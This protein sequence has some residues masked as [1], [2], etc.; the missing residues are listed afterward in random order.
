MRVL[1]IDPGLASV[2]WGVVESK[3]NRLSHVARGTITT[4]SRDSSGFRLKKIY[5][6]L[7]D[8]IEE[9]KPD[10]AAL[11]TLYFA[12]NITSA[13]PVAQARGVLLLACTEAGLPIGE[14]TPLEIKQAVVGSGR[15]EKQQVEHMVRLL[16][17]LREKEKSDHATD[18]LAAAVCHINRGGVFCGIV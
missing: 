11:E 6:E 4:A 9:Y 7:Q 18:A 2:G 12:K 8:I 15:A 14:Y 16:L 1:G 13:L 10:E 3:H 5:Q 17:G